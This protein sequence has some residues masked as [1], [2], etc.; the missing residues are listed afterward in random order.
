M[1]CFAGH[2]CK[3]ITGIKLILR[4]RSGGV[5]TETPPGLHRRHAA[6][7]SIFKAYGRGTVVPG[8]DI[9]RLRDSIE[10]HVALVEV[11][12]LLVNI[13]LTHVPDAERPKQ[14]P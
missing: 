6:A 5:T 13:G 7:S 1:T 14:G 12:I 10:T 9:K 8:R 2:P 3:R 4:R 11:T